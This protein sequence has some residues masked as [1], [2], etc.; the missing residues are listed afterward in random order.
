MI[1]LCGVSFS[2]NNCITIFVVY[3]NNDE[4]VYNENMQTIHVGVNEDIKTINDAISAI[5]GPATIILE[6]KV[7][8]E[9]VV[10]DKPNIVIDG[11][12]KAK[13]VYNDYATK[14]HADGRE[15]VTFRTYTMI[16]KAP[17]VTL[18]NLTI[19]NDAGE[20]YIVG[21][22]VALHLYADDI[23]VENCHIKAKQDTLF[24]GPLSPDLI[25]RY[26][27]LL[28]DDERF[29]SGEFHHYLDNC[30]I[31]GTVDFIFGGAS[32]TFTNCKIVCLPIKKSGTACSW[33]AAPNHELNNRH[34]FIF[35]HCKIL[36]GE[37]TSD[38]SYYLGRPWRDNGY[39][40]F[41]D[42]YLDSHIKK[43]G[44]SIWEGTNRHLG[45]RFYEEG[46]Y[47]PG[48]SK[49]RIE[50]AHVKSL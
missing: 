24:L 23:H 8:R 33:I 19:E 44:F 43:D 5:L 39:L 11:Q 17:H 46:S 37:G 50:W 12:N 14:I 22:A 31:E 9:K 35:D 48:A 40:I 45:A 34:G 2:S 1:V 36:K 21:Q 49:D 42:C 25:E 47:G 10:V 4:N 27:T 15:Y 32:A 26:V 18:K 30:V 6:D 28:P 20:G 3:N 7:Y 13:V 16:V 41:K 29:Y 38:D